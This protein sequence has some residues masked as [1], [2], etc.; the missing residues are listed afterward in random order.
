MRRAPVASLLLSLAVVAG[1]ARA[2]DAAA[3]DTS[4][5]HEVVLARGKAS[6]YG[7]RFHGRLTSSG[8]RF[9]MNELTAAHNTLPLGTRVL[10]RNL[11]NGREVIVRIND[12]AGRL[13]HRIIDLSKAAAAALG[14]VRAGEAR[15]ALIQPPAVSSSTQAPSDWIKSPQPAQLQ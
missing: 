8:E 13:G 14:F 2:Q 10:V 9:D 15:V 1:G 7:P 12:R 5:S 4:P 3:I 11:A 6:W